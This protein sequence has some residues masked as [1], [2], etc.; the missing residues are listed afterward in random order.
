MIFATQDSVP[1]VIRAIGG[2]LQSQNEAVLAMACAAAVKMISILPSAMFQP[3]VGHLIHPLSL[4][5]SNH[6]FQ[7]AVRSA[8]SLNLI[9]SNL[10]IKK[11][12][13]AWEILAKAD[14]V[15]QLISNLRNFCEKVKPIEYFVAMASLLGSIMQ[16]W[17][18]SRYPVWSDATLMEVVE[19]FCSKPLADVKTTVLHM[20]SALGTLHRW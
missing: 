15:A 20:Y 2:I 10:S 8:T 13:E 9:I 5:L 6:H 17:P 7:V 3:H 19:H 12:R 11:E 14:T 16:S 18:S 1:D 4:L